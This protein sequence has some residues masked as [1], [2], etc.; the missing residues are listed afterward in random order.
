MTS[1][2]ESLYAAC[3]K[4]ARTN[5]WR[6]APIDASRITNYAQTIF[7]AALDS[8]EHLAGSGHDLDLVTRA[9]YYIEQAHALPP[10]EDDLRWFQDTLQTLLEIVYPNTELSGKALEF[11]S[12]LRQGLSLIGESEA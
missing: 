5:L 2:E 10:I 12:D 6:T 9:V 3:L 1:A 7:K 11:V 4:L 8:A